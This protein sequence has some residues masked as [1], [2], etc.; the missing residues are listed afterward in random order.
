MVGSSSRFGG[1]GGVQAPPFSTVVCERP[2]NA[3]E[4][5][6]SPFQCTGRGQGQASTYFAH[7]PVGIFNGS[8]NNLLDSLGVVF[9]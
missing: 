6:A 4:V 5:T 9:V 2:L 3:E 7:D 8:F 1:W